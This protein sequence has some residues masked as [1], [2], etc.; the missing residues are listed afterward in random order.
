VQKNPNQNRSPEFES[1]KESSSLLR[2][3]PMLSLVFNCLLTTGLGFAK[4]RVTLLS[5]SM[6]SLSFSI[7][8]QK[9]SSSRWLHRLAATGT[10]SLMDL[11]RTGVATGA[12]TALSW[13]NRTYRIVRSAHSCSHEVLAV[14][15]F[16]KRG[17]KLPKV[18]SFINSS[19][20]NRLNGKAANSPTLRKFATRAV[21]LQ[22]VR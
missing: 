22:Y 21:L 17:V 10:N 4:T 1:R 19:G 12:S 9:E 20:R 16:R 6:C 13:V 18:T 11:S 3:R 14:F 8:A 2:D 5:P 7:S 15:A